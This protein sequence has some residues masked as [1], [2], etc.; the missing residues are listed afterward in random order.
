MN[1][2]YFD[3]AATSWPK[4]EEMMLAMDRY[5]RVVG[6]SPGRSAH[7]LSIEAGRI[8]MEARESLARLFG[9]ENPFQIVFTKNATEALNLAICGLLAPGDHAITSGMEHNSVMRPLR[10]LESLGMELSVIPCSPRG[11]L[12]PDDFSAAIKS[13]TKAIVLTHAS[14][15]TGTIMPI[16][17][18]GKIARDHGVILCVDAAQTAGALTIHIEEMNI[19][20]LAFTGHKSLFGPQ[21]TGGLHIRKGLEKMIRPLVLGGTGSRSEFERQPGF[22]PDKYESGTPNTL[23]LAGL[24]AGL[25][26]ILERGIEDI[27]LEEI[28]LTRRFLDGMK[29]ISGVHVYGP[30]DASHRIPVVSFNIE[31]L[32]PSEAALSLDEQFGIMSRPGLHCAPAAHRTIGTFPGGTVRFSFGYFNTVEEIDR[33]LE[34]VAHLTGY[35]SHGP[36]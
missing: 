25:N 8:I 22:M 1:L 10:A 23:G 2:M 12:N 18:I 32:M 29:S 30:A 28:M 15:V 31:G 17:E 4:P 5:Q 14:N 24:G 36:Q 21:G 19:D 11:E 3:N 6:G 27:R 16:R 35:R 33:A 13:N 34:A 20:L 26:Y 7:R 9:T